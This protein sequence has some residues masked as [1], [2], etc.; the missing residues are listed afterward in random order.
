MGTGNPVIMRG[1]VISYQFKENQKQSIKAIFMWTKCG[2][3][4]PSSLSQRGKYQAFG[5]RFFRSF[6][7]L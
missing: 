7:Q 4:S 6:L 3:K 1:F 2:L 5:F